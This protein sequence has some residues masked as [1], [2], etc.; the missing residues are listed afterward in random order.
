VTSGDPRRDNHGNSRNSRDPL[1]IKQR[2]ERAALTPI[3]YPDR[4]SKTMAQCLF[5]GEPHSRSDVNLGD[6]DRLNRDKVKC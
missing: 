6:V 2:R 4:L 5:R 3:G 1:P